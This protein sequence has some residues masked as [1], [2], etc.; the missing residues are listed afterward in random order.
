MRKICTVFFFAAGLCFAG[1][2]ESPPLVFNDLNGVPRHPLVPAEKLAIVLI[3]YWQDC[4]ISNG[5]VPEMNRIRSDYEKR[6]VAVYALHS[7][8]GVSADAVREHAVEFGYTFPVLLDPSLA[9]ARAAGATIVPQVAV[10]SPAGERLYLGR[11]DN[12]VED[13]TRRRPAATEH[14]LRN[15]LD[16]V[17]AGK[18]PS[19][20]HTRA[21]GCYI[22]LEGSK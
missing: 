15:A 11:I 2:D 19:Q 20:P 10:F 9:L 3:F 18:A 16:A 13:I 12:R 14:D 5:Y 1:L 4:P 6:G 22:N 7:D 8:P 17:L 21:V